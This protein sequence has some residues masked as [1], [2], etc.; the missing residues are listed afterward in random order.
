[1]IGSQWIKKSWSFKPIILEESVTFTINKT[2]VH[3]QTWLNNFIFCTWNY[4]R[5]TKDMS[6]IDKFEEEVSRINFVSSSIKFAR[7]VNIVVV[8]VILLEPSINKPVRRT[9][10]QKKSVLFISY[11]ARPN[12]SEI[13]C[14]THLQH[15]C[16]HD[17]TNVWRSRILSFRSL[18]S[19]HCSPFASPH[20]PRTWPC[21]RGDAYTLICPP[22]ILAHRPNW[23][24]KWKI[25]KI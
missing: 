23:N 5:G 6:F 15:F 2:I 11:H 14:Q 10:E 17:L 13:N 4:F 22:L 8:S 12:I 21:N 24:K 3:L 7:L 18:N 9:F 20:S 1:M 19:F 16:C 25:K